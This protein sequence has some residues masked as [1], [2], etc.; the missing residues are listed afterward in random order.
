M[1]RYKNVIF[2]TADCKSCKLARYTYFSV[3]ELQKSAPNFLSFVIFHVK[4]FLVAQKNHWQGYL[5]ERPEILG[6]EAQRE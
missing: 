4:K 5:S 1:V 6:Y 3:I 2:S